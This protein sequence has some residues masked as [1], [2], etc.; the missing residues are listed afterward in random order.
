MGIGENIDSFVFDFPTHAPFFS[1]ICLSSFIFCF[2]L[3]YSLG[4]DCGML[5]D[6]VQHTR[7]F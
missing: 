4:L 1:I 5:G 7:Y 2:S 6:I 3:D